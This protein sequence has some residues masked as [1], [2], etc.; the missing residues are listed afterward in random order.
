MLIAEYPLRILLALL[1]PSQ[2]VGF[3]EVDK[4]ALLYHDEP[5]R[6]SPTRLLRGFSP[7]RFRLPR[8]STDH[9]LWNMVQRVVPLAV[10]FTLKVVLGNLFMV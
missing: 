1:A 7:R 9:S 5:R 4:E 10:V 3:P 6:P 8:P 2:A